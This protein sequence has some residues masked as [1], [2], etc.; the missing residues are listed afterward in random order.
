[1]TRIESALAAIFGAIFIGLSVLITV[2]VLARKLFGLSLQGANELGGYALAIGATLAFT[3]GLFGRNHIRIDVLYERL[4]ESSKAVLNWLS[5]VLMACFAGLLGVLAWGVIQDTLDYQSTSQTPWATPLIYPQSLW[6]VG[7][8][9]FMLCAVG[10][11]VRATYLLVR[12]RKVEL[13]QEFNPRSVKDELDEEID[14]LNDRLGD[15]RK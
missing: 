13:N 11:A 14:G 3:I 4:C 6:Y 12:K 1:M 7:Q 15:T 5:S 10:M 8:L 9:I 2:E